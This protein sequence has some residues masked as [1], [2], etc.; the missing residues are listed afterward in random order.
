[1]NIDRDIYVSIDAKDNE[2]P[3][4]NFSDEVLPFGHDDLN[5]KSIKVL[6][7]INKIRD[8]AESLARGDIISREVYSNTI[9]KDFLLDNI[10]KVMKVKDD[11]GIAYQHIFCYFK[12]SRAGM[13]FDIIFKPHALKYD[14]PIQREIFNAW[15]NEEVLDNMSDIYKPE[16]KEKF[17]KF[18]VEKGY[19]EK[20]EFIPVVFHDGVVIDITHRA[21]TDKK[22]KRIKE[23]IC[24]VYGINIKRSEEIMNGLS[25]WIK[26]GYVIKDRN[27]Y[28]VLTCKEDRSKYYL[29]R[30]E[31]K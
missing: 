11:S 26:K 15:D 4:Q 21:Y 28:L 19:F 20:F 16:G 5:N 30:F 17:F 10:S 23:C 3:Y 2:I 29:K 13:R 14:D 8:T 22:G 25:D 18:L 12:Y 6:R 31:E 27:R 24:P 9:Y 7:E 1:M